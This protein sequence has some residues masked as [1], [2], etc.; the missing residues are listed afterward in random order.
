MI[1]LMKS[2]TNSVV[3]KA[4][5]IIIIVGMA[6]WGVDT[7]IT[8]LRGGL[9]ANL[10][11]AGK[12]SVSP[13]DLDFRV[14]NE[15]RARNADASEPV[16]KA[17]ALQSG[18]ID[19]IFEGQIGRTALLSFADRL[20]VR[21]SDD[22]VIEAISQI[23]AFQNPLT[24]ELDPVLLSDRLKQLSLSEPEF[25]KIIRDDLAIE[26]LRTGA[27]SPVF[28]PQLMSGLQARYLGETREVAWFVFDPLAGKAF[29]EPTP[30][31]IDAFYKANIDRLKQPERRAFDVLVMSADDFIGDI[32]VTDQEIATLYE[33]TKSQR[34]AEPDQRTFVRMSFG[35]R[36][37]A[38]SAFERL[39]G[40]ADPGSIAGAISSE[41]FTGLASEVDDA[42]LREAMFG[43][44]R[45]SGAM[46]GPRQ[47]NG[48]W[49]VA[50]LISVQP[51]AVRPLEEVSETIRLD[52]AR[53]RAGVLM[54]DKRAA[55]DEA[56]AAGESLD[57]IAAGVG[58]PVMSLAPVAADG[59]AES[60]AVFPI[61]MT[62]GL[63]A[64]A[65]R[66][67][68]GEVS[69]A[70]E[71]QGAMILVSPSRIISAATPS[72]AESGARV[73]DTLLAERR[74]SAALATVNQLLDN[75][76]AGKQSFEAAAASVGAVVE[77]LPSPVSR[78]SAREV[79]LPD[80]IL[81]TVFG[82][83][84]GDI[85]SL[86]TN[87]GSQTVIL[88]VRSVTPPNPVTIAALGSQ[89]TASLTTSLSEDLMMALEGEVRR[90]TNPDINQTALAAYKRGISAEP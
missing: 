61:L 38:R 69:S 55:I 7:V 62:P 32:V 30:E 71:A 9:G 67:P 40:G 83:K 45:Q 14:E 81:R 36:D 52:L 65:F 15:L 43:E 85:T 72:L 34:F 20:G 37:A 73:R 59:V 44:G 23:E 78:I 79:G 48:V 60:G 4:V 49:V 64:E 26:L 89:A 50:R 33:A 27:G 24:G 21:P 75:V 88:H 66:L 39:A 90:T 70:Y 29:P 11:E 58:V 35:S 5:L 56:I 68:A 25:E 86:P 87:N 6:F 47:S 12:R 31:E 46:F 82:A 63:L 17:Q 10:I 54:N 19:R 28:A 84:A 53:E 51:G 2:L 13:A 74:N 18:L 8:Q 42:A 80:E 41:T 1:S 77:Q 22:A 3:G 57:V 16:T 76:R